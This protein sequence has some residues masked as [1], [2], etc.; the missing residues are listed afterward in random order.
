MT[1]TCV[2]GRINL[3]QCSVQLRLLEMCNLG[4]V[5]RVGFNGSGLAQLAHI[6]L[7]VPVQHTTDVSGGYKKHDRTAFNDA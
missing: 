5:V 3:F 2:S 4:L 6:I 1:V 7:N